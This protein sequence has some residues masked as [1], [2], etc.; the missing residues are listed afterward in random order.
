MCSKKKNASEQ[1]TVKSAAPKLMAA[2]NGIK[3][4]YSKSKNACKVTFRLPGDAAGDASSVSVVGDF[5]SWDASAHPMKKLKNG[6]FTTCIELAANRE[7]Q[8]RYVIDETHWENDRHADKYVKS[9]YGD[10][11]NSVV[12]V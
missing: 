5:N 12:V 1:T 3:K 4:D 11:D 9:P 8:F 2:K 6:D 10:S 7:Y